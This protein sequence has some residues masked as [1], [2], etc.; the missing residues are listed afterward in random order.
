[1]AKK[2]ICRIKEERLLFE[3]YAGGRELF[4]RSSEGVLRWVWIE[5]WQ[6]SFHHWFCRHMLGWSMVCKPRQASYQ[7]TPQER[8]ESSKIK[9]KSCKRQI[10]YDQEGKEQG[11]AKRK[12]RSERHR[13]SNGL[14]PKGNHQ[15]PISKSSFNFPNDESLHKSQENRRF[16]DVLRR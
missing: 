1:M 8:S 2:A 7:N 14:R 11:Q 10:T 13:R 15:F 9:E 16:V 5:C 4:Q 12:V 6:P 3:S